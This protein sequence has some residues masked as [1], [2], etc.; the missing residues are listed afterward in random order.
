MVCPLTTK[1]WFVIKQV[2]TSMQIYPGCQ[3][4][5][6]SLLWVLF[7]IIFHAFVI[8]RENLVFYKR[9]WGGERG[10]LEGTVRICECEIMKEVSMGAEGGLGKNLNQSL[11]GHQT[12]RI[13]GGARG[14]GEEGW[15][16]PHRETNGEQYTYLRG[17]IPGQ[18]KVSW[19]FHL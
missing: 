12:I 18:V 13:R 10:S 11:S 7:L 1:L 6:S 2:L 16:I 3:K 4:S 9:E 14:L 8:Y 15:K 17:S 5:L 19:E